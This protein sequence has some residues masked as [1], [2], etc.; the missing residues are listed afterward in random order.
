ML[1]LQ[2]NFKR[3]NKGYLWSNVYHSLNGHALSCLV[4][5]CTP[6][7]AVVYISKVIMKG[8]AREDEFMSVKPPLWILFVQ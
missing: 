4:L 3:H 8:R 2:E 6:S 1:C 7:G 5:V